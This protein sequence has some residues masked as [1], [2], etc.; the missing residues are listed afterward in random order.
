MLSRLTYLALS[1]ALGAA[2]QDV[3]Q[4]VSGD[5]CTAA[6]SAVNQAY[7]QRMAALREK[8]EAMR[9]DYEQQRASCGYNQECLTAKARAYDEQIRQ[10]NLEGV[11]EGARRD[12][13]IVDVDHS[14]SPPAPGRGPCAAARVAESRRY[15]LAVAALKKRQIDITT[16]TT[17]ERSDCRGDQ[18]CLTAAARNYEQKL[19]SIQQEAD[20]EGARRDQ[21]LG[22]IDRGICSQPSDDTFSSGGNG[23]P[24][25][26]P[27]AGLPPGYTTV[28]YTQN[29]KVT[30]RPED[31][32]EIGCKTCKCVDLKASK[33]LVDQIVKNLDPHT[34]NCFFYAESFVDGKLHKLE[35]AEE[36]H[37]EAWIDK[38][39]FY[40]HDYQIEAEGINMNFFV[41]QIGD[42]V[43]V[44]GD[45]SPLTYRPF[46]HIGIVTEVDAN[47]RIYSIRQKPDGGHCA[48]DMSLQQFYSVYPVNGNFKYQLYRSK[49]APGTLP[50]AP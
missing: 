33:L 40:R 13:A 28:T 18:S 24:P 3:F 20:A 41:A 47:G 45:N 46:V 8:E 15:E 11:E 38:S 10:L 36:A 5:D 30:K 32:S 23:K 31:L 9:R 14:C 50:R 25:S 29:G 39:Y 19:R 27:P 43:V 12:K 4:S 35:P 1:L 42:L 48:T 22:E 34:Y 6:R 17:R 26:S 2:A 37:K 44:E 21:A 49:V 7:S 16:E